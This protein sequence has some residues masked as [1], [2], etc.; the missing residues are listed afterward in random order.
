ME[1]AESLDLAADENIECNFQKY[2]QLYPE[3][4]AL[5]CV[6]EKKMRE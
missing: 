3:A 6:F 1:L 4:K 2:V 5:N